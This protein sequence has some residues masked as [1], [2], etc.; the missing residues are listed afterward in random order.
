MMEEDNKDCGYTHDCK[1][2]ENKNSFLFSGLSI[3]HSAH[4]GNSEIWPQL[5]YTPSK[6]CSQLVTPVSSNRNYWH[7]VSH[8]SRGYDWHI[9]ICKIECSECLGG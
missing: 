3:Q 9:T 4:D 5:C 2:L 1:D 7:S 6:T 8:M